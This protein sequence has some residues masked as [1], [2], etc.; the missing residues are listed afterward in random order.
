MTSQSEKNYVR[1][2]KA[3]QQR[4]VSD[5]SEG[6]TG[7]RD[8][9]LD[10]NADMMEKRA[11][12][13]LNEQHEADVV[14]GGEVFKET[15]KRPKLSNIQASHDRQLLI[16]DANCFD[17]AIDAAE[18][19]GAKNSLEKMLAHQ[20]A[21]CHNAG[22]RLIQKINY[23]IDD[24]GN[25]TDDDLRLQRLANTVG[26]LMATFQQGVKTIHQLRT[27]GQQKMTVEHVNVN[28]GGQAI[29]GSV[30]KEGGGKP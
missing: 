15:L 11:V 3:Q 26:K 9:M 28:E 25:H 20:M 17:L 12:E 30:T 22:M 13:A 19:V 29:V 16:S 21:A 18:T 27:G 4:M 2:Q 24:V 23:A 6:N 14:P 1:L 10:L 8:S 5:V 7:A